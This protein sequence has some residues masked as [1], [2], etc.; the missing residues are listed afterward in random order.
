VRPNRYKFKSVKT[1][2][3]E[4]EGTM[5]QSLGQPVFGTG[6]HF[7]WGEHQI[8]KLYGPDIPRVWVT[9]LGQRE[10]K[11]FEAGFPV[12]E[13]GELIEIDDCLGQVYERIKGKSI[14][15][16]L[17][18][19]TDP[20]A[21]SLLEL[22]YEFAEAHAK[23][24]SIEHPQVE[25]PLQKELFGSVLDRIE[26]LPIDLRDEILKAIE[27]MPDGDRVCHGDYHPYNVIQSPRGAIVIDWNNSH[28]GDPLEDVARTKLMLMGFSLMVP[29][30]SSTVDRFREAYLERYAAL[31]PTNQEQIEK[32][33]PIVSAIRLLDQIPEIQDW[34]LAQ[35]N[36]SLSK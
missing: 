12:P 34:L 35:I 20:D 29:S 22:A 36:L 26:V 15:D 11:L 1:K 14:A 4:K 18:S 8:I 28:L 17:L 2:R 21:E 23:I 32:W 27:A 24:H 13:V 7:E 3:L 9:E 31:H 5:S 10:K 19:I 6:N 16:E 33:W 25:M 30:A